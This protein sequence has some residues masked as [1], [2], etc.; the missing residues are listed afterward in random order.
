MQFNKWKI[1]TEKTQLPP[2]NFALWDNCQKNYLP[3]GNFCPKMQNFGTEKNLGAKLK[4]W[5]PIIYSVGNLQLPA[6]PT[7]NPRRRWLAHINQSTN[8]SIDNALVI[9]LARLQYTMG[10]RKRN[11]NVTTCSSLDSGNCR[12]LINIE[13]GQ[14]TYCI[15]SASVFSACLFYHLRHSLTTANVNSAIRII[16]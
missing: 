11:K 8:Q 4:F 3:V 13:N 2:V 10:N 7:F 9:R 14:S 1:V 5:A 16:S 6:P 12:R 15:R